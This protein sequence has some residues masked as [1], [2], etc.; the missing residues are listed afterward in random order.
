MR[1]FKSFVKII[2]SA[3][4]L[5]ISF[6]LGECFAEQGEEQVNYRNDGLQKMVHDGEYRGAIVFTYQEGVKVPEEITGMLCDTNPRSIRSYFS[7]PL[8]YKSQAEKYSIPF[9]MPLTCYSNQISL[10]KEFLSTSSDPPIEMRGEIVTPPLKNLDRLINFLKETNPQL[11][12]FDFFSINHFLPNCSNFPIEGYASN[13]SNYIYT[14]RCNHEMEDVK[15]YFEGNYYN[16]RSDNH[17]RF[18][19]HE[20]AHML[21]ATDKYSIVKGET[22]KINPVTGEGYDGHDIM[23]G[24]I[25]SDTGEIYS[26]PLKE[27][28]ISESTAREI[29][30]IN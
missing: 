20:D 6:S 21:G 8:W 25:I 30:W 4:A 27:L 16:T 7:I 1:K 14:K 15:D 2:A 28:I 10:P 29:G 11:D 13:A 3:V 5:G 22:C 23:C 24:N 9:E 12:N 17:P 26:P 19:A 18:K